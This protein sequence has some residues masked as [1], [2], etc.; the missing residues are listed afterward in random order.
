[1]MVNLVEM[2]RLMLDWF[3]VVFS[4]LVVFDYQTHCKTASHS[5]GSA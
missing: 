1:M 3:F 2:F 4:P 5:Q